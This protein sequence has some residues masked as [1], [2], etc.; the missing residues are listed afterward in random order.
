VRSRR[1]GWPPNQWLEKKSYKKRFSVLSRFLAFLRVSNV[2][3]SSLE[4]VSILTLISR[5]AT[6]S[7]TDFTDGTDDF[8]RGHPPA[9]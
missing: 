8:G 1:L 6:E 7:T 5:K 3:Q 9:G 2:A 4:M